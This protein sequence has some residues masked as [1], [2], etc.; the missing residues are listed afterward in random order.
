M[1][2]KQ[3]GRAFFLAFVKVNEENVYL[4]IIFSNEPLGAPYVLAIFMLTFA[5]PIAIFSFLAF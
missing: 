3:V 1:S 4:L 2:P 5:H